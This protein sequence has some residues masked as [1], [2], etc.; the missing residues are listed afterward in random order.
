M[1]AAVQPDRL[2]FG[3]RRAYGASPHALL[4]QIDANARDQVGAP[5]APVDLAIDIDDHA[6]RVR[7][8][9]KV[10]RV[11]NGLHELFKH[12]S[13]GLHQPV[14]GLFGAARRLRRQHLEAEL[15]LR[16]LAA[17]QAALPGALYPAF[18]HRRC[19]GE[20]P[21]PIQNDLA[22]EANLRQA[23]PPARKRGGRRVKRG[24]GCH[25]A[26][27]PFQPLVRKPP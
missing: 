27:W 26:L 4:G 7:Q 18:K 13:G 5:V 22:R 25:G 23:V 3:Q 17:G 24:D 20:L 12:R 21:V 6:V 19:A 1:L 9:G 2:Q 11:G 8:N 16:L 15:L 10:A 14:V